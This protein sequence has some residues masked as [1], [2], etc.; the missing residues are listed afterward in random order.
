MDDELS[1]IR[2]ARLAELQAQ[3]QGQSKS[4]DSQKQAQQQTQRHL[5]LSQLLTPDAR[6]RLHRISLV[7]PSRGQAIEDLLLQMMRSGQITQKI[8]EQELVQLLNSTSGESKR[9]IN[10][11]KD[12]DD[13][14]EDDL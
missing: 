8:E 7:K 10:L 11:R 5:Q 3:S 9:I 13:L 1:R 4:Q 14:L 12:D 2:A 6:A